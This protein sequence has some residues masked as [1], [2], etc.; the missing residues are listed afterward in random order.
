[1]LSRPGPSDRGVV[2]FAGQDWW[3]H[4]RAHSDMQLALQLAA[5]RRVL[6]INSIGTRMPMPGKSTDVRQRLAR[7]LKS[8]LRGVKQ[9]VPE[10]PNFYVYSPLSVPLYQSAIGRRFNTV[11]LLAQVGVVRW[12]LRLGRP[13]VIVTPP[14]AWEV[15]RRMR[16]RSLTFNRSDKHS[17]WAE[18]D[19]VQVAA[20]ERALLRNSDLVLYVSHALMD[21]DVADAGSRAFFLDHGVDFEKFTVDGPVAEALSAVPHP[22]LGFFGAL[23]DVVLDLDLIAELADAMP[24]ASIV[25][26]GP[27]TVDM[28]SLLSRGNVFWFGPQPH[29]AIPSFGR[30]FDVALMPWLDNDWIRNCNPVKL[31][32]YLALGLRIVTIDFP[33]VRRYA[34]IVDIAANRESFIKLCQVAATDPGDRQLRRAA[35]ASDSWQARGRQLAEAIDALPT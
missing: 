12:Y 6:L 23:R 16:R 14:T 35:V 21:E 31:K 3:Y 11:L 8:I 30:G 15:V 9:P 20:L 2:F 34:E 10:L 24:Q 26:V 1:M 4:N 18:V 28:D 33:E 13:D 32:E 27:S 29:E 25:L 17:A 22:R 7:K 19:Q 5:G